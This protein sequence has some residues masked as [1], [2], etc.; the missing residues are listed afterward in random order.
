[1]QCQNIIGTA[2]DKSDVIDTIPPP[3]GREFAARLGMLPAPGSH[4]IGITPRWAYSHLL[5]V[6]RS[7]ARRLRNLD[8]DVS[9]VITALCDRI[10]SL[11]RQVARR[12]GVA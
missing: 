10:D 6:R 5:P 11:E 12:G 1:M 8:R 3:A 4:N 2:D 7:V 9:A